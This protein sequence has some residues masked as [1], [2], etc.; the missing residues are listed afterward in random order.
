[1]RN[2]VFRNILVY[3]NYLIEMVIFVFW[4]YP[5]SILINNHKL[6]P[7]SAWFFLTHTKTVLLYQVYFHPLFMSSETTDPKCK[8]IMLS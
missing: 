3:E 5:D 4:D 6:L 7:K 8:H 1:M 2:I